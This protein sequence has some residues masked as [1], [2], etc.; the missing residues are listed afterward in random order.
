MTSILNFIN[1]DIKAFR[2]DENIA[3]VQ[4]FFSDVPY[5]HFPIV[6]ESVYQG[7]IAAADVETFDSNKILNDYRY[8]YEPFFVRSDMILLDV[9]AVCAK[10]SSNLIPVL[11]HNNSYIGYYEIQD[12]INAFNET[13]FLKESGAVLVVEK[14][15]NSYSMSQ[16]V[17]IVESN[18]GKILGVFV[19]EADYQNVQITVKVSNVSLNEVIQTFRR[20]E[21]EIVSKH[22]EDELLNSLKERSDYLD[23]YLN[24]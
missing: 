9:M 11:D 24:I 10:N 22:D 13:T 17:Q 12:I 14:E 5:S 2:N 1:N 19:S 15:I 18:G 16:V 7:S 8:T 20:Y 23:K 4:D 6:E 21:Y 3:N